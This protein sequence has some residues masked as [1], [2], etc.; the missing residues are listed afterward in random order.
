LFVAL[1]ENKK[2][3]LLFKGETCYDDKQR[4]VEHAFCCEASFV[5]FFDTNMFQKNFKEKE[6]RENHAST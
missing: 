6:N 2:W 4:T 3:F 5:C 1:R